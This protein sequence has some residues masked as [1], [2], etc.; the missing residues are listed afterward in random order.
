MRPRDVVGENLRLL[1]Q[2]RDQAV[3]AAAM[4][5]AF[6]DHIDVG[7]VHRAHVVVDDDGALDGE[8]AAQPD[9]RIRLDAG[10][11]DDHVAVE[12]AAVLEGEPGDL[13]IAQD[14]RWSAS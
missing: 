11:D 8:P 14:L 7:V 13:V 2:R 12:R 3:D 5:R 4:L 1:P 10:G 6:A 9:L